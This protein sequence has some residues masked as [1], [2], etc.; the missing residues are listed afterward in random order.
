MTTQIRPND[1]GEPAARTAGSAAEQLRHELVDR[2]I[3]NGTARSGRVI[4]ALRGV[5]RERFLPGVPVQRAYADDAIPTKHDTAGTTI[6]AASQPSIVA[7]MLEQLDLHPGHNVFEAGAGTGYNAALIAAV[8]GEHGHVT[9]L[10]V[11][12]DIVTVARTH[13]AEAGVSNTDV[14]LADAA[15]GH[16]PYAPYDR[17]VAT[18]GAYE[19]PDAWLHQLVPG[20]RLLVPLRL[21]GTT[22]RCIA[23]ERG[24]DGW[25]AVN[26]EPAAFMPLRGIGADAYQLVHLTDDHAVQLHVHQDQTVDPAALA[27]VF[28]TARHEQWTGV[29]I[30]GEVPTA[31]M[32]LWLAC[33]LGNALM[34]MNV[35]RAA[36]HRGTVTPSF[37]WGSMAT[38]RGADLAYLTTRPASTAP[39]GIKLY[40]VGVISH[41]PTSDTLADETADQIRHWNTHFRTRTVAF[42]MPAVLPAADPA[43]GRF[44]LPREHNPIVVAWT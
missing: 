43:A 10:D 11:D 41:G 18:V 8:V 16:T 31:W 9:T 13:L 33:T 27:G 21:R 30:Q 42:T 14:V 12:M 32:D 29:L 28:D 22:T 39:D 26:S 4:A 36:A 1:P 2:L 25:H 34:R 17:A 15:L 35:A 7:T 44:V 20:G 23:F 37:A 19:I 6:S 24:P 38:V 40:E 3:R 5:P